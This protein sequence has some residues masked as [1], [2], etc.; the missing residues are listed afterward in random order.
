MIREFEKNSVPHPWFRKIGADDIAG[1]DR[2]LPYP[3]ISKPVDMSGSRG[4]NKIEKAEDLDA[5]LLDSSNTGR[6]GEILIEEFMEGP[7]VSVEM[8]VKDRVPHVLQI[9]DKL[10]SGAPH[11][12]ELGHAQPSQHPADTQRAI[13]DVA[14]GAAA[15]LGLNNCCAHAEIIVTKN[16]P[17]MVEIGARMGGDTIQ[18]QLILYS[19]GVNMPYYAIKMALGEDFELPDLSLNM[20]STIRF[21]TAPKKGVVT[22]VRVSDMTIGGFL[23]C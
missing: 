11:F 13:A 5:L 20:C 15:A 17:K 8:L 16:G 1:L 2:D 23:G 12:V 14:R 7:E 4:I 22:A 6:S 21:L 10:T 18:E 9:T 3:L 19:K